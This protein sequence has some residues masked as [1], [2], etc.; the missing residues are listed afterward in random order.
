MTTGL[1][2]HDE[3]PDCARFDAYV[4]AWLERDLDPS[5]Q[6]W[7]TQHRHHCTACDA[8]VRDLEAIVAEAAALPD[9]PAPRA[10]WAGIEARLATPVIPLPTPAVG[11]VAAVQGAAATPG[12]SRRWSTRS[13]QWFAVAATLLVAVSSGI[14]WQVAKRRGA[15]A[16]A[17]APRG[18]APVEVLAGVPRTTDGTDV[19]A[20]API[21]SAPAASARN[22]GGPHVRLAGSAG[23]TFD[24]ADPQVI[25]EREIGALR[26][27][28]DERFAE[29]DSGTVSE[30]RRNLDI[31]DRAIADSRTALARDPRSGV[32]SSQLDRALQAKLD[33]LRRVALL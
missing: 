20:T 22:A 27:L 2:P 24:A 12:H 5:D 32:V 4:G 3:R 10:L 1:R 28:V 19:A 16:I 11:A 31:I 14:T 6:A 7:M 21:V 8:V 29:L 25:Y 13:V 15:M 18:D 26:R 17:S 33:L 23:D 30:L 9:R